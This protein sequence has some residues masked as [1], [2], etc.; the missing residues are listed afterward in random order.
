MS[1]FK[2]M[3]HVYRETAYPKMKNL[4]IT[5]NIVCC[6]AVVCTGVI[7]VFAGMLISPEDI[8]NM[9]ADNLLGGLA[10]RLAGPELLR[11]AFHIFV[12]IVGILILS[13]PVNTSMIG[14]NDVLNRV[15]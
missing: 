6:Y 11:L 13:C 2:T 8:R 9:Y 14:A 15:A 5:A 10:M 12:V 1:G 3:Q 7:T 4:R